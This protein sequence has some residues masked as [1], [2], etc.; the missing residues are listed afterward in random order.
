MSSEHITTGQVAGFV[1][2]VLE[3]KE[4]P[5]SIITA[6]EVAT[7]QWPTAAATNTAVLAVVVLMCTAGFE[8]MESSFVEVGSRFGEELVTADTKTIAMSLLTKPTEAAKEVVIVA[9]NVT[10]AVISQ[11]QKPAIQADLEIVWLPQAVHREVIREVVIVVAVMA[12]EMERKILRH[13]I[14]QEL[15]SVSLLRAK[16]KQVIREVAIVAAKDLIA[17]VVMRKKPGPVDAIGLLRALLAVADIDT[18]E[19]HS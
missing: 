1:M 7:K 8:A 2:F 14:Q 18:L 17:A 16:H 12:A 11:N 15:E 19:E 4:V 10:V 5:V 13:A 9:A 3:F 6:A